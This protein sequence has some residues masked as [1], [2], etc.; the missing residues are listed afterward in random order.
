MSK[1]YKGLLCRAIN[2]VYASTP[3][4]GDGSARFGGRFNPKGLPALYMTFS[5]QTAILEINQVGSL[6]PTTLVSYEADIQNIFNAT[7]PAALSAVNMTVHELSSSTW[8]DEMRASGVSQTQTF[9]KSLID[10]GFSAMK[11]PS[12]ARG[13][14]GKDINIVLWSWN[15]GSSNL[16]VI[17][18]EKRL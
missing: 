3:L 16:R 18:D 1:A 2:P 12:F 13:A 8:R 11:V 14:Q 10:Q 17:D 7:D 9:A 15:D 5:I 4:S 6:Q